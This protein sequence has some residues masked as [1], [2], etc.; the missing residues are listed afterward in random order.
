MLVEGVQV[1]VRRRWQSAITSPIGDVGSERVKM[2]SFY[3]FI[4][5][6]C[7]AIYNILHLWSVADSVV[8]CIVV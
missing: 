2:K 3:K 4:A 5:V 8:I 6:M 7:Q 1:A